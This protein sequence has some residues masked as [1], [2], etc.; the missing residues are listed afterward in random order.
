V[1]RRSMKLDFTGVMAERRKASILG[2][3]DDAPGNSVAP[4]FPNV[5][6][7]LLELFGLWV[8]AAL[9]RMLHLP[10]EL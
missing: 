6:R 1:K 2:V 7:N 4:T 8:L 10:T 5:V 9:D 3:A